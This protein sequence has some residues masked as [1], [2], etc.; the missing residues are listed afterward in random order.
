[1]S[2]VLFADRP[3]PHSLQAPQA[4][5]VRARVKWFNVEKGFG[6]ITPLDGR[7]DAFLHASVLARGGVG[8]LC[9]GAEVVCEIASTPKGPQVV[10]VDEVRE[11]QAAAEPDIS[12]GGVVK[13]YQPD[14]GFG[15]VV[16][17][18]GGRDVFLHKSALRRSGLV[19]IA[20]GQRVLMTVVQNAKGREART[21]V[22]LPAEDA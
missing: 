17:E 19:E 15:F 9:E 10:R 11:P 7:P 20:A 2:D 18:D 4:G 16:A 21:L 1:V 13:W 22:V 14:K 6:F 12:L 3:S 5:S 8:R